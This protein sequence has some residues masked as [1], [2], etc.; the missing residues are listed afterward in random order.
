V[1]DPSV[2]AVIEMVEVALMSYFLTPASERKLTNPDKVRE[3]IGGLK[4]S[5]APGPNGIPNRA[6]K[7]LPQRVVSLLAQIFNP[8]VRTHHFPKCRST[9]E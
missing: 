2:L 5:K 4:D 8:V 6:F 7:H 9:L 3:A 1:T